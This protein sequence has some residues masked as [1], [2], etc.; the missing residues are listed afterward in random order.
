MARTPICADSLRRQTLQAVRSL[1]RYA[2]E[3]GWK[4]IRVV[5]LCRRLAS[6]SP[7]PGVTFRSA[8]AE[9]SAARYQLLVSREDRRYHAVWDQYVFEG[10]DLDENSMPVAVCGRGQCEPFDEAT[11]PMPQAC[12]K[13]FHWLRAH[14]PDAECVGAPRR[15]LATQTG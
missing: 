11:M 6:A 8:V 10:S 12:D 3:P 15:N 5:R 4:V 2:S 7:G 14:A 1:K 9:H 13:C